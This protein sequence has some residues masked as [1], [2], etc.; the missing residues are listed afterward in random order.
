[1]GKTKVSNSNKEVIFVIGNSEIKLNEQQVE[2]LYH[3]LGQYI[4]RR[5][6]LR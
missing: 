6:A 5:N 2:S 1:M 3:D 4:L